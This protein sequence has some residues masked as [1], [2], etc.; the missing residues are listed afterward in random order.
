[1]KKIVPVLIAFLMLVAFSPFIGSMRARTHYYLAGNEYTKFGL[2]SA[3]VNDTSLP[4]AQNLSSE[5]INAGSTAPDTW[6]RY[7]YFIDRAHTQTYTRDQGVYW[8]AMAAKARQNNAWDNVSYFL[9]I[10][11]HYWLDA[12]T[13]PHND[14]ARAYF[15]SIYGSD[16]GYNV[17][18]DLHNHFE[19]QVYYYAIP[20]LRDNYYNSNYVTLQDYINN[21]AMPILNDFIRKSKGP[22]LDNKDGWFFEW[23]DG[24]SDVHYTLDYGP[25][26]VEVNFP[27]DCQVAKSS[28]DLAAALLYNACVRVLDSVP[29]SVNDLISQYRPPGGAEG[30]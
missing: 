18:Y 20:L 16:Q 30:G 10:A 6:R 9:G 21:V 23:A 3:L 15:E 17:W 25:V 1:M 2:Y 24:S 22:G 27:G 28:V 8:L 19:S 14:N 13:I 26:H 12:V 11:S 5:L 4:A 7:P 29:D